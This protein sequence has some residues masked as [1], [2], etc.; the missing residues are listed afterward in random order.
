VDG[1]DCGCR[2]PA[3]LAHGAEHDA[4]AAGTPIT[5]HGGST[6]LNQFSCNPRANLLAIHAAGLF[7]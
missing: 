5:F 3:Q 1:G 4:G 2:T 7:E 6:G